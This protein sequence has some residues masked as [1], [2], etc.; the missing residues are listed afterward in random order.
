MFL[1][2][3]DDVGH[4]REVGLQDRKEELYMVRVEVQ[5]FEGLVVEGMQQLLRRKQVSHG[6]LSPRPLDR[7]MAES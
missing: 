2:A 5:G 7:K 3:Q 4:L 1:P 6:L